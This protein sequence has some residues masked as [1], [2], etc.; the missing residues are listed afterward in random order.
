MPRLEHV[1]IWDFHPDPNATSMDDCE[2]VIQRH[3]L[4][5][6]QMRGL[7]SIPHFYKEAIEDCI[8]M[9]P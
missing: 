5:K 9:D 4:N 7:I 3:R 8:A 2:Y 1:S 6:Q